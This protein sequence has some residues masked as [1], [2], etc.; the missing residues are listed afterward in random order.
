MITR[1][2]FGA[3]YHVVQAVTVTGTVGAAGVKH[4]ENQ[5]TA[6]ACPCVTVLVNSRSVT[7]K[8]LLFFFLLYIFQMLVI[9]LCVLW[10]V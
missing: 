5:Q 6:L 4:R 10:W 9:S 7:V 8:L 1:S 3:L 2:I